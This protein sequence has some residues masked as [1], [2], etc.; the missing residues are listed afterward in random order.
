[1]QFKVANVISSFNSKSGGPPRTV[2]LIA[3]AGTGLWAADLFTTDYRESRDDS[4]LVREFPGHV[5]ISPSISHGMLGGLAMLTGIARGFETQLLSGVAPDIV[6]IH[7]LW[8]PYLAAFAKSAARHRIPYVV[9]PH[10]M[11]EPWP[12]SVHAVRK[13]LA[14]RSY[15]GRVLARASAI[16]ATSKMEAANIERRIGADVPIFVIPNAVR[17]PDADA[18]HRER[19][20]GEKRVLLFLS[21]IHEKKGLDMLLRAW[22]K[23]R[24]TGWRLLIVGSGEAEYEERLRAFCAANA[25]PDVEFKGHLEGLERESVFRLASA[26]VLPTF[27]EN[28]GNVVAE[29]MIRGLPVITT[30][31]TPWSD[32]VAQDCGWY[33]EPSLDALTGAIAEATALDDDA[34]RCMGE[35]GRRYASGNFTVSAVRD[36]L[37]TMYRSVLH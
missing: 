24:P 18:A 23:T 34:L 35:R 13:S 32:I 5:N 19:P 20:T 31:G 8:S 37:L 29:A 7:G 21:R 22:N 36:A 11:L 17:E 28:F 4:L 26:F 9:A 14:L 2:S 12:L 1:M 27:S 30:T 25:V 3:A 6:H 10:G 33:I 15:Q 16:H